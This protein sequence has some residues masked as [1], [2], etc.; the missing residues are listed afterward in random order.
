MV[1]GVNNSICYIIRFK[2][3]IDWYDVFPDI[4][5]KTRQPFHPPLKG[6]NVCDNIMLQTSN[7]SDEYERIENLPIGKHDIFTKYWDVYRLESAFKKI[8]SVTNEEVV[9]MEA[10]ELFVKE[11]ND[12]INTYDLLTEKEKEVVEEVK[13]KVGEDNIVS[14]GWEF[15]QYFY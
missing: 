1:H 5:K 13:S 8:D 2:I 6:N 11:F 10:Y 4:M 15:K 14:S 12:E 3:P 9:D 7:N